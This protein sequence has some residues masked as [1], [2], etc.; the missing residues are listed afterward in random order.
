MESLLHNQPVVGGHLGRDNVERSPPAYVVEI[1]L[2]SPMV[3]LL[4]HAFPG[5]LPL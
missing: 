5:S 1:R 3:R 4:V 2:A